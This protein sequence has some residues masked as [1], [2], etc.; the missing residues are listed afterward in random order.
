MSTPINI[1]GEGA[2][3]AEIRSFSVDQFR[4]TLNRRGVARN[5]FY[6]V[7]FPLTESVIKN[8]GIVD[9]YSSTLRD[10]LMYAES[11]TLPGLQLATTE[12]RNHGI[13]PVQYRPYAPLFSREITINFIVDN[14][15][16][17]ADLF[18]TWMRTAVNYTS[19]GYNVGVAATY[20]KAAP[21]EVSYPAE[22]QVNMSIKVKDSL[23]TGTDENNDPITRPY[24]LRYDLYDAYPVSVM[25]MRVAY[26]SQDQLLVLPVSFNYY[27]WHCQTLQPVGNQTNQQA[28]LNQGPSNTLR[29]S[30]N[31]NVT[32]GPDQ[33][34]VLTQQ[35]RGSR[36]A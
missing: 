6:T 14:S 13:G 2:A 10:I 3:G 17:V 30:F 19:E 20:N 11:A 27:H 15:G 1:P 12:I 18:Y 4:A 32:N 9:S 31:P 23:I 33:T 7:E 28:A 5:N 25:D 24:T 22:Y 16:I 36:V 26:G 29:D 21:F 8:V 35:T 34:G